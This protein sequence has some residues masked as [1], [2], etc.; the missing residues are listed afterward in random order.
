MIINQSLKELID[1]FAS[2][3]EKVRLGSREVFGSDGQKEY[4][5]PRA[6]SRYE[7]KYQAF[8]MRKDILLN[9]LHDEKAKTLEKI[10][11]KKRSLKTGPILAIP[12]SSLLL[13][14]LKLILW[15]RGAVRKRRSSCCVRRS[16]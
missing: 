15:R 5:D 1:Q 11:K 2:Q 12:L 3:R 8:K 6:S 14:Q 10:L 16:I 9:E 4:S 7:A 13:S